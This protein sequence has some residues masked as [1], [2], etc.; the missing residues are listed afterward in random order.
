MCVI[1]I[2]KLLGEGGVTRRVGDSP[3]DHHSPLNTLA[4]NRHGWHQ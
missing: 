1:T 3:D 4:L 2:N